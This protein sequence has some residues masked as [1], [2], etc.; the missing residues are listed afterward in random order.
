MKRIVTLMILSLLV[1]GGVSGQ[2]LPE[3]IIY[4]QPTGAYAVG[5][6]DTVWIDSARA[7]TFTETPDDV[8]Q[9]PVSIWYPAANDAAPVA[10]WIDLTLAQLYA[11]QTGVP[12][13]MIAGLITV[14]A[15]TGAAVAVSD[16]PFPVLIMSHGSGLLPALYTT[17]AESLAS[18][19]YV[20]IGVSHP[21]D[22]AVAL[23]ADGTIALPATNLNPVNIPSDLDPLDI[24]ELNDANSQPVVT[25][26][27]GDL[28]FALDQTERM[29]ADDPLLAGRLDVTRVG[30]FGHSLGGATA[31]E[32]LLVDERFDAAAHIDGSLYSDMSAGS[33]RPILALF[34]DA[35]LAYMTEAELD[36]SGLSAA[37]FER[38]VQILRR[39]RTLYEASPNAVLVTL[40]DADHANFSDVGLL[41]HLLDDAGNDLGAIDVRL[42]LEI[43]DAYLVAFFDE[44]LRGIPAPWDALTTRYP[45]STV[46]QHNE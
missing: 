40:A 32:T 37:D 44:A 36:G 12:L 10:P 26:Q 17:F 19:G 30:V 31:I 35:T 43:S 15:R 29:N 23:L 7:E 34:A 13:D 9:V 38:F 20:V 2:E 39:V 42:A 46:E 8:R 24:M 27:A 45:A 3:P 5:R 18:H 4:P 22:A 41:A 1:A 11:E 16:A 21:Y 25:V 14:H 33:D 28:R 6:M